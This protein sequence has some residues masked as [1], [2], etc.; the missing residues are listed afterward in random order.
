MVEA[1]TVARPYAEAVFRLAKEKDALTA[2]SGMLALA[3][4]VAADSGMRVLMGDPN[5]TAGRLGE[6]FLA[7]CGERL[8]GEAR[9]F[10]RVLIDNDRIALL[11]EIREIYEQLKAGHEGVLEARILS[12][13]PLDAAQ[14]GELTGR[15][16]A[17]YRRKIV[18]EVV[19]EPQLIGGVK[20]EVGDEVLDASVRG[21]LEALAVHLK[22]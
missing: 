15:L 14:V 4:G 2:W 6:L 12:A 7:V 19:L 13:F 20:I 5:L 17:R 18:A 3:A 11:P 9:N 1:V 16:E 21:Q 10:V 22:A 8:T